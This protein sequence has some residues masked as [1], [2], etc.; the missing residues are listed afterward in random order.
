MWRDKSVEAVPVFHTRAE[1]FSYM[2]QRQLEKGL[3]PMDAA[4]KADQFASVFARNMQLPERVEPKP[5]GIDK[6]LVSIDKVT[7][8]VDQHPKVVELLIPTVTFVAGLFTGKHADQSPPPQPARHEPIDF[9]N[10]E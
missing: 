1:A 2:L 6:Y 7:A 10:I 5:E 9:D 4:D 8:W 3:D